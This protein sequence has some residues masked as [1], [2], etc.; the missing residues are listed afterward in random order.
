MGGQPGEAEPPHRSPLKFPSFSPF[1]VL[2][3]SQ[4]TGSVAPLDRWL[5][6]Q[7]LVILISD[8]GLKMCFL[9]SSCVSSWGGGWKAL[10]CCCRAAGAPD[11]ASLGLKRQI[12]VTSFFSFR[13]E[14]L[15]AGSSGAAVAASSQVTGKAL[16]PSRN[17]MGAGGGVHQVVV[18]MGLA[19]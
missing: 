9:S 14:F 1:E 7:P 11:L 5:G 16:R 3:C 19:T 10:G 18:V 6:F 17:R 8:E 12:C 4:S 13:D 2:R 15:P